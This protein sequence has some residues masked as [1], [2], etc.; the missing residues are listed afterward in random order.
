VRAI[1]LRDVNHPMRGANRFCGPSIISAL[2]GMDTGEAAALL[3][4]VTGKRA[5]TGTS[6]Y[7][8]RR[9]LSLCGVETEQQD[10]QCAVPRPTLAGWHREARKAGLLAKGAIW[11]LAAGDHWQAVSARQYVCG[12]IGKVVSI[13]DE[14]V[15]RRAR[16][17]AFWR[18]TKKSS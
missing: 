2:T 15:K 1:K 16:V 13:R 5:I 4:H 8:V 17:S 3:R 6:Y 7:A 18:V 9:A 10:T 12:R 14:R 11:L